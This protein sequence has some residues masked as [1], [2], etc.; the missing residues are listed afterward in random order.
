LILSI[1]GGGRGCEIRDCG[2]AFVGNGLMKKYQGSFGDR[3]A[4]KSFCRQMVIIFGQK[5]FQ[6]ELL[7]KSRNYGL[8]KN[9]M[10]GW[11]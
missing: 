10:G 8:R 9:H 6:N 1:Q 3:D 2:A 5:I 7:G 4:R 11:K